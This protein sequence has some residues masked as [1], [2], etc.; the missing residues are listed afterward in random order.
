LVIELSGEDCEN[1]LALLASK[2]MLLLFL[3]ELKPA[4]TFLGLRQIEEA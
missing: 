4:V 1:I 3:S 2:K